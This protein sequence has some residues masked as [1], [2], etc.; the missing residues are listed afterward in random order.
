MLHHKGL[1]LHKTAYINIYTWNPYLWLKV[2]AGGSE[3]WIYHK[4]NFA[5]Q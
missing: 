3:N 5:Y 1:I 2:A 4:Y